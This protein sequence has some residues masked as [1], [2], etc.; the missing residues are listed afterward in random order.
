MYTR[1]AVLGVTFGISYETPLTKVITPGVMRALVSRV[2][3]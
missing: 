1:P 2:R 3:H